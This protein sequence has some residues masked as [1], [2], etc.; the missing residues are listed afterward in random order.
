MEKIIARILT[1]RDCLKDDVHY[2]GIQQTDS[3]KWRAAVKVKGHTMVSPVVKEPGDALIIRVAME[4]VK[5]C[6]TNNN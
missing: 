3:G 6:Y 1:D 5:Q 4:K 2:S